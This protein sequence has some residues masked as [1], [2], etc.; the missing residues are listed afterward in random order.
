[1]SLKS[2]DEIT[3]YVVEEM[4]VSTNQNLASDFSVQTSKAVGLK[5]IT[6]RTYV[7]CSQEV[8][9]TQNFLTM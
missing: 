1:M 5:W 2:A 8:L 9:P 3:T 4:D 7:R 6:G